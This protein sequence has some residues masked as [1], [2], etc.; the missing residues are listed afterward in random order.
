[1]H[2]VILDV[3]ALHRLKCSGPDMQG[4]LSERHTLRT[5]SV[6]QRIGKVQPCRRR[7]DRAVG[8]GVQ[9]LVTFAIGEG[10]D[11]RALDVWWQWGLAD[12]VQEFEH[13]R[14]LRKPYKIF[15]GVVLVDRLDPVRSGAAIKV[16]QLDASPV[17]N[18]FAGS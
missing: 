17:V 13:V 6:E 14:R 2:R 3:I 8:L 12:G 5:E 7:G 1:M 10:V 11:R 15:A 18:A 9:C 4:H 16:V